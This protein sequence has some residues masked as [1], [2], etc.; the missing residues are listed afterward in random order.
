MNTVSFSVGFACVALAFS[1]FYG[2][3]ASDIFDVDHKGRRWAWKFQ[4]FWLNFVGSA[5]GWVISW[6][7]LQR[8]RLVIQSPGQSLNLSDFVLLLIAFIGVTGFLP[9]SVVSFIQGIRDI[10]GK[11]MGAAHHHED[12]DEHAKPD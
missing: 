10:A 6:I 5:G 1:L 7:V 8:L 4:Q 11:I 9:L 2:F 12:N 3:K